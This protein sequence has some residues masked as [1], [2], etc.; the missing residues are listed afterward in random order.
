MAKLQTELTISIIDEIIEEKQEIKDD[1]GNTLTR[2]TRTPILKDTKQMI[3]V[4]I[5]DREKTTILRERRV[6]ECFDIV[7]RGKLWYD[8]LTEKQVEELDR[9]YHEWLDVTQTLVVP[10]KPSWL[11]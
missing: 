6:C 10:E 9:W 7:N 4:N 3:E 11:E 5:E 8:K 2:T 1:N